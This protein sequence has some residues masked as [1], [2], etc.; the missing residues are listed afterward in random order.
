MSWRMAEMCANCPFQSK[1]PGLALRRSLR[2]GRFAEILNA[3]RND[4]HFPCHKTVEED[5]EGET[6]PGGGP[7]MRVCAGAIAWQ[8]KRGLSSQYQRIC[9]RLETGRKEKKKP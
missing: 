8:E 4:Q 1:G 9:E 2:L 3:L 7:K 5:D 6:L